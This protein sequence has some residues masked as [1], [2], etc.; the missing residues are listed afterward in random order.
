MLPLGERAPDF[1]LTDVVSDKV[2]SLADFRH[3]PGLLVMFICNHCPYVKHI[4]AALARFTAQY[5]EPQDLEHRLGIVAISSNDVEKYPQDN[6]A[7]MRLEAQQRGYRF[8]Y[9]LDETQAIA[10]AYQA[11]CTPDFFLFDADFA[12]VYRGQFDASRP[13]SDI[14]VTGQDLGRAIEAL[15]HGQP[16]PEPQTPS[17]GCNIKWK[18]GNE[19]AYFPAGTH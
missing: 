15:L 14:P 7:A 1:A 6:A 4:A 18:P 16:I 9:L 12:L 2:V 8:P 11:A 5:L 19:P 3:R 10:K 13:G 17:L